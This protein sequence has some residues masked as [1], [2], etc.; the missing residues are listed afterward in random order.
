MLA[1]NGFKGALKGL[2]FTAIMACHLHDF[3]VYCLKSMF[4][5][6]ICPKAEVY[7]LSST[8]QTRVQNFVVQFCG[9][10]NLH[11]MVAF[12]IG[13]IIPG[14]RVL[15]LLFT[16]LELTQLFWSVRKWTL[17]LVRKCTVYQISSVTGFFPLSRNVNRAILTYWPG[18]ILA[19][20]ILT[21]FP[22]RVYCFSKYC[23]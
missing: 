9:G 15:K 7:R 23:K 3:V 14:F 8:W 19:S 5:I 11:W 12:I 20:C 6:G 10:L 17:C 16:S 22:L 18:E 21:L 13:F 4:S 1:F 2:P